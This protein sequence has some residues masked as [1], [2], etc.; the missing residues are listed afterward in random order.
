MVGEAVTVGREVNCPIASSFCSLRSIVP[1]A[2]CAAVNQDITVAV[3][4]DSA[5]IVV[6]RCGF[7][8]TRA[9]LEINGNEI[10]RRTARAYSDIGCKRAAEFIGRSSCPSGGSNSHCGLATVRAAID[11]STG[12]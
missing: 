1:A 2:R 10:A 5:V 4:S 12:L 9:G 6:A 8:D 11:A 3:K 7:D